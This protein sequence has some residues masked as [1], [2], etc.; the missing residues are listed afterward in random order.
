MNKEKN[1]DKYLE[2]YKSFYG[3]DNNNYIDINSDK[4]QTYQSN[5]WVIITKPLLKNIAT[6]GTFEEQKEREKQE[7][8]NI[9]KNYQN[10]IKSYKDLYGNRD[11]DYIYLTSKE[12]GTINANSWDIMT[13]TL[14]NKKK[15]IDEKYKNYVNT[16]MKY[17]D[18]NKYQHDMFDSDGL[19]ITADD[20]DKKATDIEKLVKSQIEKERQAASKANIKKIK[21]IKKIKG[22]STYREDDSWINKNI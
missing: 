4:G 22:T 7:K 11:V 14:E 3:P 8:I 18:D 16:Y 20:W 5:N 21:K 15:L 10:Y 9:K 19:L 1:Y 17:Y 12:G 13:K 6:L 2:A